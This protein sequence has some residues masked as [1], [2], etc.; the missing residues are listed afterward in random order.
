MFD[1]SQRHGASIVAVMLL[2]TALALT[3]LHGET[4]IVV[5][6]LISGRTVT[7]MVAMVLRMMARKKVMLLTARLR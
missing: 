6:M 7:F 1:H 2:T 4:M 3:T 5:R